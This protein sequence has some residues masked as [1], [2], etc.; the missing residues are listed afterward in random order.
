MNLCTAFSCTR[1]CYI[2]LIPLLVLLTKVQSLMNEEVA[3]E[4][5]K[6]SLSNCKALRDAGYEAKLDPKEFGTEAHPN[7]VSCLQSPDNNVA[8]V[9]ARDDNFRTVKA[10]FILFAWNQ[11]VIQ[12]LTIAMTTIKP[13]TSTNTTK[14]QI[15][16]VSESGKKIWNWMVYLSNTMLSGYDYV[17]M[18]DGDISIASL[19]WQS[20][21]ELVKLVKP[22]VSQAT[23][24]GTE[25]GAYSS[26]HPKLR[27]VLDSRIIA[28]E[29]PII[30]V[31]SPLFEVNTWLG[32]RDVVLKHT[33]VLPDVRLGGE[34]CFD[35]SWCHYARATLKGH[36][37]CGNIEA[38]QYNDKYPTV[39]HNIASLTVSEVT[40]PSCVVFYQTAMVHLN[41]Q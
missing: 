22:K 2:F 20:H 14:V 30:E 21:L 41:K 24:G 28:A 18:M 19:N 23:T 15:I 6:A 37:D 11:E 5:L 3:K 26:A 4:H 34:H 33:E 25:S 39:S 16:D 27:P 40:E 38:I 9:V 12:N 31:G 13:S 7:H 8:A 17:W 29:T 32:Y 35:L 10:D 36:Q 1:I